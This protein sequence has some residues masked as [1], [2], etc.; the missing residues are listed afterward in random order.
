MGVIVGLLKD[1]AVYSD[2]EPDRKRARI[3][4]IA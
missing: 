1:R 4:A 2:E 3:E